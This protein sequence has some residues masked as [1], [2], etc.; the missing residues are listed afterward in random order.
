MELNKESTAK[1]ELLIAKNMELNNHSIAAI[2]DSISSNKEIAEKQSKEFRESIKAFEAKFDQ[3]YNFVS[4]NSAKTS[5]DAAMR[6][7]FV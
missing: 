4:C 2:K 1:T 5:N 7:N 6:N 3:F